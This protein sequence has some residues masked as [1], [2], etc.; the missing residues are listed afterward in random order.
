MAKLVVA[1]NREVLKAG[2]WGWEFQEQGERRRY[3]QPHRE[4]GEG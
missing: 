2:R 3:R 1:H 4:E